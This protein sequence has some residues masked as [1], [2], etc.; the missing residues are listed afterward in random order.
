MTVQRYQGPHVG[1]VS[2]PAYALGWASAIVEHHGANI[3]I[4][5]VEVSAPGF[6]RRTPPPSGLVDLRFRDGEVKTVPWN[7]NVAQYCPPRDC[8]DD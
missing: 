4:R 6:P 3:L 7:E 1:V 8:N 5:P 2:C